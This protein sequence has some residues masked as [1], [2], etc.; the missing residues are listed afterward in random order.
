M[1]PVPLTFP[2][3]KEGARVLARA[4]FHNPLMT[5]LLPEP[6]RRARLLGRL[7]C[8]EVWWGVTAG[9]VL[10]TPEPLRG[11]A[12]WGLPEGPRPTPRRLARA[13]AHLP[14]SCFLGMPA[15]GLRTLL[16]ALRAERATAR[17][18]REMAPRPHW[19][20]VLLGVDPDH[21]G[22]GL[23]TALLNPV[24]QR[25]REEGIPCYLETSDPANLP[26]YERLGFRVVG[27]RQIPGGGPDLWGM[28]RP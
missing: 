4:F 7:L 24:L 18:R 17:L 12:V 11:L 14:G 15:L 9:L 22:Q 25:A 26:F 21:Q 2:Q 23:G 3:V 16:R 5:F 19:Y 28:L 8:V 13:F 10:A 27:H 6:D 1:V 20:L